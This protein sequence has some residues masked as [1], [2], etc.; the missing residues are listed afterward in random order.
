MLQMTTVVVFVTS[1]RPPIEL[2]N[3]RGKVIYQ[4]DAN[5][6]ND[7]LAILAFKVFGHFSK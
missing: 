2:T 1:A 5:P 6:C 3:L 4:R 7:A